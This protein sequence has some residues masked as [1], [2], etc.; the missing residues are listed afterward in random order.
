MNS[1]VEAKAPTSKKKE[2][3]KKICQHYVKMLR[4][5]Y[6]KNAKLYANQ[7][8]YSNAVTQ[9]MV[10]ASL[11]KHET[12]IRACIDRIIELNGNKDD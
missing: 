9:E 6:R 8:K 1:Y 10:I 12:N 2:L 3:Q 11:L 7:A 5:L 4:D